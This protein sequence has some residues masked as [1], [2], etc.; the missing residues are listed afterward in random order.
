MIIACRSFASE[1]DFQGGDSS[2]RAGP[3]SRCRIPSTATSARS[4]ALELAPQASR[5]L[6]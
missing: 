2:P 3:S 4:L 5:V 1:I 6:T